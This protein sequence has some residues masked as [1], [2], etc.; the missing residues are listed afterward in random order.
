MEKLLASQ[1]S[2][3]HIFRGQQVKGTII[4]KSDQDLTLDLGGKYE[5][6]LSLRE[7]PKEKQDSIKLGDS[8]EAFV[9][10]TGRD[11]GQISL[12]LSQAASL[13]TRS[14][15]KGRM[16]DWSRFK[17]A[18]G[19]QT[20]FA[21]RILEV[22][23]GGLIVEI[24]EVR[25]FLPNSQVGFELVKKVGKEESLAG[26]IIRVTVSEVDEET[27]KLILT[28]KGLVSQS[29]KD[30]LNKFTIGDTVS[31]EIVNILPFGLFVDVESVG[32]LV[33]IGEVS[34]EREENLAD[35]FKVGQKV[36]TKVVGKDE[37][38]GRLNLSIKQLQQDPFTKL[39]EKFQ[40]DDVVKGTIKSVDAAG[41]TI[42]LGEDIEGF[43]PSSRLAGAS[44]EVGEKTNFL[45]DS[46]DTQR[47]KINLA[48]FVTST[49]GLIYK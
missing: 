45:V 46:I 14:K 5:G 41:I 49:E 10:D 31:G 37:E 19:S 13:K 3:Q 6:S 17:S 42:D 40:A 47:R 43:L 7:F 30:N 33:F 18:R 44:Y 24:D 11:S 29:E 12:S 4:I 20:E 27:N 25:G 36:Q 2:S 35:K 16:L 48:P 1:K 15:F 39:A 28:Q 34:W 26:Q 38:L 23:K 21:G 22:N 8:I 9:V 32:G